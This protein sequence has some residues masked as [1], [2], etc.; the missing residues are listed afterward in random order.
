MDCSQ[1]NISASQKETSL[2]DFEAAKS[3]DDRLFDILHL[4]KIEG[5]NLLS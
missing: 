5:H 1:L 3:Q 2:F 4:E